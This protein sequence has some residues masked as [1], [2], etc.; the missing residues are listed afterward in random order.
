[1]G[2]QDRTAYRD[3]ASLDSIQRAKGS[4]RESFSP[5]KAVFMRVGVYEAAESAVF[6]GHFRLDAA[7]GVVVA[8]DDNLPFTE[9]PMRSSCS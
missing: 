5:D 3:T 2:P 7:P 6:G 4:G 9:M 8:G 1:V